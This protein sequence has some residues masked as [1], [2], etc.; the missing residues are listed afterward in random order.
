MNRSTFAIAAVACCAQTSAAQNSTASLS[1]RDEAFLRQ[2]IETSLR[3]RRN[4]NHPFGALLVDR[5]G[6]ILAIA[7]NTV[8]TEHD[9]TLH[10]ESNVI[11]AAAHAHGSDALK[12][13]TLYTSTEPCV[14]CS[15][16]V[17]WAGI[18]RVVFA[19]AE[20]TLGK[21]AGDD[22]LFPC[23]Q[24]F[25]RSTHPRVEV[26]GPALETEAVKAHEGYWHS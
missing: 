8:I 24:V 4:G 5:N 3:A 19:C 7:E 14:M 21:L 22:F 16:A 2:A 13:S 26:I 15:G 10:A 20:S 25:S 12:D 1:K 18:P 6:K 23:R 9:P 11:R 17:H